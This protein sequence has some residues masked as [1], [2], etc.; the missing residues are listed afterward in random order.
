MFQSSTRAIG[1]RPHCRSWATT[2]GTM[3]PCIAVNQ[4]DIRLHTARITRAATASIPQPLP[5]RNLL[6]TT[7]A[8]TDHG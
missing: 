3:L 1:V 6:G 7:L 5:E 4:I 8:R 2:R